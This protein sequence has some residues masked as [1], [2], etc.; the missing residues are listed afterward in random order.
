M[1]SFLE[2]PDLATDRLGGAALYTSDDFF[3]QMENLVRA[4]PAVW[5]EHEYTDRGKWMD[6][7]E[8]RR[9]RVPGHDWCIVRLGARGVVRGFVVDTAFFRGNYPA[10]CAIFGCV[11]KPHADQA[12]LLGPDTEWVEL[13]PRTKLAGDSKNT[14]AAAKAALVTHVRLDIFPDGG[15]ARLRVHGEPQPDFALLGGGGADFDLACIANGGSSIACSDNFFGVRHNLVMPGRAPN[16]SE[17]WESRRRRDPDGLQPP[18]GCDWN[19]VRLAGRARV[20][21]VVVDTQHFKGNFPDAIVLEG[22]DAPGATTDEI[23]A[24]K[25]AWRELLGPTKCIHDSPHLF[26]DELADVG[27]VTHVRLSVYPDGGV[28]RLRVFGRLEDDA[29]ASLGL[30]RLNHA[31]PAVVRAQLLQTCGSTAWAERVVE[32]RPFASEAALLE[33]SDAAWRACSREDWLEAFRAHPP[34]GG[35]RAEADTTATEQA[36]SKDEQRGTSG[37]SD[38]TRAALAEMNAKYREHFGYVFLVQATGKS[39]DEMLALLR[40]RMKNDA[41][42]EIAVAAE[43]ERKITHLRLRKLLLG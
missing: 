41:E 18:R 9:K 2:L 13:L 14:F 25:H 22:I 6:G 27:A 4:K 1:T 24:G 11:A 33:A 7:W 8:S 5:L 20:R 34:I 19:V 17:G 38:A 31:P 23:V 16:M 36:W 26:T 39:A 21:A 29:R 30:A 28:S 10:E 3:A 40:E 37:A 12:T 35:T 43:E 42:H 32:R 15:V